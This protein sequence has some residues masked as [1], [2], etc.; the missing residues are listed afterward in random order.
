MNRGELHRLRTGSPAHYPRPRGP[1]F[2][3]P[4]LLGNFCYTQPPGSSLPA[5]LLN[6]RLAFAL[7]PLTPL[8]AVTPLTPLLYPVLKCILFSFMLDRF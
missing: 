8:A 7:A 6:R 1:D 2:Y 3:F 4:T 5:D